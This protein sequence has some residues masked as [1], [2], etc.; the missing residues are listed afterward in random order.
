[1]STLTIIAKIIAP[2][3]AAILVGNWFL[4]EVKKARF[5]G[6]PWYQPYLSIPG[7]II[8]IAILVPIILWI[9]KR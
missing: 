3:V 9:I 7:F 4:S 1:M 2:L 5:K 8:I 6:G